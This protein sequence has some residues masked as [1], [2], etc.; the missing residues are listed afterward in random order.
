MFTDLESHPIEQRQRTPHGKFR[1]LPQ[2]PMAYRINPMFFD[3][4]DIG[5]RIGKQV[6]RHKG[7]PRGNPTRKQKDQNGRPAF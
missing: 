7:K 4:T 6:H 5:H 2:R 1:H 3:K